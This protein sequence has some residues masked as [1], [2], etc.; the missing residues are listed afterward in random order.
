MFT[1]LIEEVGRLQHVSKQGESMRLVIEAKAIMD[2]MRV[3][4]SIAVNGICLT[5][6][7]FERGLFAADVTPQTYR[8]SNLHAL[9]PGDPLNLERAMAAG[10]R[11]GGHIVQGHG[12][13]TARILKRGPEGNMVVFT[14]E[15]DHSSLMRYIV[16]QGSI[17]IDG[18]SLTV[19]GCGEQ[20]FSVAIIPHTWKATALFF[21]DAGS[22]VNV[23]C[24]VLGKY[25]DHLLQ[26]R[27]GPSQSSTGGTDK[28][29]L[30]ASFLA[31]H[32][33]L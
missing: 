27:F 26:T 19:S 16:P 14:F 31:E 29:R 17:T 25:V 11:F 3:G 15:A 4:D 10:G 30:S 9:R 20:T 12:D 33:F 1:G 24:D 7:N 8:F 28:D 32:G 23:E 6:T 21:K 18:V 2:D 13:G 22:R 5:V